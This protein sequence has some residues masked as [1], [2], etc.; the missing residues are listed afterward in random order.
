MSIYSNAKLQTA[1]AQRR[2]CVCVCV[3][4]CG[5]VMLLA[6]ESNVPAK[7]IS[8]LHNDAS[9]YSNICIAFFKRFPKQR[10]SMSNKQIIYIF[11]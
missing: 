2:V 6:D 8:H 9:V 10:H 7:H 11:T 4:V 5:S 3:C 1:Q